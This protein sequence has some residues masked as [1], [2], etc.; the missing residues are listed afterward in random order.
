MPDDRHDVKV[1]L[2]PGVRWADRDTDT[3]PSGWLTNASQRD[4]EKR[5]VNTLDPDGL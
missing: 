3:L 4:D 2:P 1:E 5:E